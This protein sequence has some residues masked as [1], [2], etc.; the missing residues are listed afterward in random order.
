M[1]WALAHEVYALDFGYFSILYEL[2]LFVWLASKNNI[3][4]HAPYTDY[5]HFSTLKVKEVQYFS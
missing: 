4:K 2:L 1:L 3:K 5:I